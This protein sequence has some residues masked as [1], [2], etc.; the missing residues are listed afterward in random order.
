MPDFIRQDLRGS[1][2]ERV[3]LSGAEFRATDLSNARFRGVELSRVVMRGVEMVDVDIYGEI[4]NFTVNGVDVAPLVNAE[5]DRRYPERAKM[6]PTHADGFRAAWDVV[7]RLWD[8][9]VARAR[10]LDP[11]LLHE[12][13]GGE[14]SFIETL[15]HLAFATDCWIRRAI[16]G[17]PSPWHPLDLPWDEMADTPGVPRDREARPSL[18]EV[19]ELR[20]DRMATMREVVDGLTDET[21][22]SNTEPVEGPGWPPARAFPV[23]ECLLCI[24]NEEWEHR[25]YAERDLDILQREVDSK[26][27]GSE[28][29]SRVVSA[30]REI[31]ASAGQIFELIADPA[32]QPR[33]DGN[34]NLAEAPPGQRVRAVGDVFSMTTT[35]GNVR[36]NHV[37][38]FDE[39][40][41]IAWR[42]AEPD[43]EP[44][45]H[46]WRWSLEPV[47]SSR[48][49]VTHTYDWT[50]LTDEAR[51]P[52]AR[53][54]T[55]EWL[56]ASLDRLA[57]LVEAH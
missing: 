52:R 44:P 50:E 32:Q 47:D 21:L 49:R 16:L 19:L 34:D 36:E 10:A 15:R 40:R 26:M 29:A 13:V 27:P 46:L 43:H 31:A 42:P 3:D 20:R 23:R 5:L 54:T 48:T 30:S 22:N 56:Q 38:E 4:V 14:W 17:D 39:G 6:R 7:E 25:L 51:L 11:D 9:T 37:V 28:D 57:D 24:L 18:D 41:L 35:K 55:A 33:W 8:E 12:S 45:G 1:R 53:A 2:F